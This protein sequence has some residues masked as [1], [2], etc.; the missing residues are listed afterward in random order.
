[1]H[2]LTATHLRALAVVLVLARE[3]AV[4]KLVQHLRDAVGGTREHRFDRRTRHKVHVLQQVLR[5]VLQQRGHEAVVAG[6]LAEGVAHS[7]R[8]G[9][10]VIRE[11]VSLWQL[12]LLRLAL[13]T[14]PTGTQP[15]FVAALH[16]NGA[17]QGGAHV[18][19]S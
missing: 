15:C 12:P 2:T 6:A 13:H 7:K 8:R 17:R 1:M 10:K 11:R 16:L 14:H 18:R 19:Q 9:L 5:A 4:R 3:V